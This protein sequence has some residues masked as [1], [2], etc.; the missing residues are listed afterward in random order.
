LV[1]GLEFLQKE[2]AQGMP[3]ISA[4]LLDRS[5]QSPI[6]PAAV[7]REVSG[8]RVA[9]FGLLSNLPPSLSAALGD[10]VSVKDPA[11][12]ARETVKKL[13]GKADLFILLSDLGLQREREIATSVPGIDFILGGHEGRYLARPQQQGNTHL[14]QS[15]VKGMYVGKL[16]LLIDHLPSP[17][18]DMGKV[19]QIRQDIQG[20]ERQI[21]SFPQEKRAPQADTGRMIQHL[22]ERKAK[23]N[24][25]LKQAQTSSGRGNRFLWNLTSLDTGIPEDPE[26]KNWIEAAEITRD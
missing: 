1:Q 10:K 26:V 12:A 24:E 18:Q 23:L 17:F 9:F 2:A 6:F 13:Q 5:T 22:N 3:F 21:R 11:E 7:I 16:E 4:N 19:D 20:I 8:V 25:D 15:S 14:L